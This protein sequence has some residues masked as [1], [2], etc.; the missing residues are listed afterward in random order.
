MIILKWKGQ[1]K[2]AFFTIRAIRYA[3]PDVRTDHNCRKALLRNILFFT[4]PFILKLK[5]LRSG[6]FSLRIAYT[7]THTR[8]KLRNEWKRSSMFDAFIYAFPPCS[9]A[10]IF[11]GLFNIVYALFLQRQYA[12]FSWNG[13]LCIL[14]SVGLSYL[15]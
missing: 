15:L 4:F 8:Q 10:S 7:V 12:T 5:K 3:R 2:T 13:N 9:G 1:F 6:L 11:F 14:A